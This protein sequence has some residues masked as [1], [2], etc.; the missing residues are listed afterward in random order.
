MATNDYVQNEAFFQTLIE[1][2]ANAIV[3]MQPDGCIA[4]ASPA[5]ASCTGYPPEEF[6]GRN[7]FTFIHPDDLVAVQAALATVMALANRTESVEYRFRRTSGSYSWFR[8]TFTNLLFRPAVHAILSTMCDISEQ[9]RAEELLRKNEESSRAL[10]A[11]EQAVLRQEEEVSRHL[12]DLFMQ[13]PAMV[14]VLQGSEHRLELVNDAYRQLYP[15][16]GFVLEATVREN[17]PDLEDQGFFEELDRVY[18]SGKAYVANEKLAMV[19]REDSG[20][21]EAGYF[22]IVYQP[23]F[24][25]QGS[26]EGIIVY[27]MEVTEQVLARKRIQESEARLRRLIDANIVGVTFCTLD[28]HINEANDVFLQMV[29]YTREDLRAGSIDWARMTPPEYEELDAQAVRDLR[30]QGAIPRPYEKAYWRKNGTLLSVVVTA[31][32][33]DEANPNECIAF[34]LDNSMQRELDQRKDDFISMTS[35]EL[36]T[37]VTSIK[38][39]TQVL[40]KRFEQ[41]DEPDIKRMLVIMD[42]QLNKLTKLIGDLLDISKAQGGRLIMEQKPFDLDTL[43]SETIEQVQ[44]TTTT[45]HIKLIGK[46]NVTIMGD[47]DRVGQVIVNLL[48]NAIKYSPRNS[49]IVVKV[50]REGRQAIT[51]IQDFGIGI[52]LSHHDK[53]FNQF[54]RVT[55]PREPYPGLGIGLYLSRQIVERHNGKIWLHSKKGEGSIFAFSLPVV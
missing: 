47:R 52:D 44:A 20:V 26:V 36:K 7:S 17:W 15:R 31:A 22:N 40:L 24:D 42:M 29:G 37:P 28:G 35:H 48:S 50:F 38:G 14:C 12:N 25:A 49:P 5:T 6:A 33:L 45:Q 51:W 3:L 34:I 41:R 27:V 39:L 43:V 18:Q 30:A 2:S 46:T 8:G 11:R 32:A 4:Y 1:H 9:K 21:R 10:L 13:A 16:R 55:D 23:V 53:L 54:Y 19:D